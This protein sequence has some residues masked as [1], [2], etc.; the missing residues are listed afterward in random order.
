MLTDIKNIIF[1]LGG[2]LV[3]LDKERC[4][5]AF[6]E[7]GFPGIGQLLD[8]CYPAAVF[9]DFE[10]GDISTRE[11]CEAIRRMAGLE[12]PDAEICRAYSLF[13]VSIPVYKLRL[14]RSLRRRGFRV[15][16]LSNTNE[17]VYPIVCEQMFTADGHRP[18][19]HFEKAYLSYRMHALKPS[20]EIF[21]MM[22]ADSGIIP[23]E[24]LFLD[25]GERNIAAA[26]ELGF[27]VYMPAAREDF[28]FLFEE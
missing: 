17:V 12:I 3:D 5:E 26:R 19:E 18:E 24:S 13:V 9:R 14:L 8:Y 25:D 7:L 15:Y 20:P 16:L 6:T 28:T 23:S 27:N 21:R 11:M 2:V 1:D 22:I 10:R 4:V